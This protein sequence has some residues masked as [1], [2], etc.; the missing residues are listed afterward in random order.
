MSISSTEF[1]TT[2][3]EHLLDL[4]WRQWSAIGVSG[5]SAA[6][7]SGVVDP[8]ALLLLTL[9]VGRYDARL[10]DGA[11]DWLDVNASLLNVQRL[12][13]LAMSAPALARASLAAI[14]EML[15]LKS[16]VALKW[17]KLG[18]QGDPA[19]E[20]PLFFQTDGRP[21][22][23]PGGC[24]EIFRRHGFLRPPVQRRGRARPFPRE[25]MPSL[26]L[27]LRSLIGVSIRCEV[28]C[29]LGGHDEIHP[30]LVAR[31]VGQAPRTIQNALAE[32]VRSGVVQVRTRGREKVY[33]LVPGMLDQL[34]RPDGR[35]PW[36]NSV[37]LFR[38]LETLW[39]GLSDPRRRN[40]DP[41]LLASEWRRLA[42]EIRPL[43][44]EAGLG[45]PLR[46]ESSFPGDEYHDVFIED[47]LRILARL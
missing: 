10:F 6:D 13:N 44:G 16:S 19:D 32:M 7:E 41:L 26:L 35:T 15:G 39:L 38:A 24:D 45:Q 2:V 37:S 18:S 23:A 42:R 12:R 9:T 36:M 1:R 29:L 17:K 3:L 8:E 5:Y 21:M 40:L 20:I 30:S 27:R 43:L 4:S 33:A 47:I 14:A 34:L 31:L 11:L 28:L 46:E 25:G 22:P